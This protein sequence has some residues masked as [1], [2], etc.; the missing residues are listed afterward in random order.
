[1]YFQ[2]RNT[3]Q[4]QIVDILT[5]EWGVDR[6]QTIKDIFYFLFFLELYL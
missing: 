4:I 1:M 5:C 2:T 6:E 3:R